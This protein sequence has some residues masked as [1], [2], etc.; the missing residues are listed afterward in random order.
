[1]IIIGMSAL[2]CRWCVVGS[3]SHGSECV[4]QQ[5]EHPSPEVSPC[6]SCLPS[7]YLLTQNSFFW[8]WR[9]CK[10]PHTCIC[11]PIAPLSAVISLKVRLHGCAPQPCFMPSVMAIIASLDLAGS[12]R[13]LIY[14]IATNGHWGAV[15][16]CFTIQRKWKTRPPCI[17]CLSLVRLIKWLIAPLHT[18][19]SSTVNG[20]VNANGGCSWTRYVTS[21]SPLS[22]SL[23]YS[24]AL[25]SLFLPV[26]GST[27]VQVYWR[28]LQTVVHSRFL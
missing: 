7:I 19:E 24:Q 21:L 15:T 20:P 1:M 2:N 16:G 12:P 5:H 3:P 27:Q 25:G 17:V 28:L 9:R 14:Y 8:D 11:F 18:F 26:S 23:L 6:Y 4:S 13:R 22:G 10:G